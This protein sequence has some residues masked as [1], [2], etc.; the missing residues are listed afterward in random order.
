MLII[1]PK[2]F[3]QYQIPDN[4][5]PIKGQKCHCSACGCYFEQ[6]DIKAVKDEKITASSFDETMSI[7]DTEKKEEKTFFDEPHEPISLSLFNEPIGQD[8]EPKFTQSPLDYVPEEFKPVQSK[9][10]PLLSLLLWLT[11]GGGICYFAYLQK[12]YLM[13]HINQTIEKH[14]ASGEPEK[15]KSIKSVTSKIQK[16]TPAVLDEQAVPKVE[17]TE[18]P[19]LVVEEKSTETP[20]APLVEKIEPQIEDNQVVEDQKVILNE[21][22]VLPQTGVETPVI[23]QETFAQPIEES[24]PIEALK[25][26]NVS[27]EIG[28]NEVGTERLLIKGV[29]LNT[30]VHQRPLPA[31]KAVIYDLHDNVVARKRIVYMQKIIDGNSELSFETS[32][33]PAPKSV[34]RIEVNF[35]E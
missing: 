31:T 28:M 22:E 5:A 7:F 11:L 30:S 10:T 25:V 33:V 34:S 3:T 2:C 8:K 6:E 9:K 15:P 14:F 35:D 21:S 4:T 16:M 13:D 17:K 19:A 18:L 20:V 32:V 23:E 26:Q 29:V 12:D 1:C 24:A 27:Y